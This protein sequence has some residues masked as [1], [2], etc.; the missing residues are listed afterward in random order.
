MDVAFAKPMTGQSLVA[1][2]L[3]NAT[4]AELE[5]IRKDWILSAYN[6]GTF[7]KLATLALVSG[8]PIENKLRHEW[9]HEF[10][11]PYGNGAVWLYY[12]ETR[13]GWCPRL[14]DYDT[15]RIWNIF[16]GGVWKYDNLGTPTIW[17]NRRR[18][19][20]F[21]NHQSSNGVT[22]GEDGSNYFFVPGP[23]IDLL[24]EK[25]EQAQAVVNEANA[26]KEDVAKQALLQK[27]CIDIL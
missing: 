24:L 23:W 17:E 1:R 11:L 10:S 27:L 14:N 19:C 22:Y 20:Y 8:R 15:V 26:R 16:I 18:V 4:L 3:E 21:V 9:L 2:S 6:T 13:G 7:G 25:A 12:K 5:Q